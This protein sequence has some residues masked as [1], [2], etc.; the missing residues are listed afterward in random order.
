MREIKFRVK[1][2]HTGEWLYGSSLSSTQIGTYPLHHFWEEVQEDWIDSDTVGEYTGLHD[3]NSKEIYEGDK[4]GGI[5]EDGYIAYC[6]ECKSFEYFMDE[7][8]CSQ[9][10]GDTHWSEM[11]ENDG[12]LEVV[13]NIY[14]EI[15]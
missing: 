15:K 9:C 2:K 6:D 12:K 8:G 3:K 14:E 13:G 7:F 1:N 10:S 4:L 11:V 5:W